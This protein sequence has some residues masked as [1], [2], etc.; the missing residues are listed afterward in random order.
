MKQLLVEVWI[1]NNNIRLYLLNYTKENTTELGIDTNNQW[2]H[3]RNT[4]LKWLSI[5]KSFY[6]KAF[7]QPIK[8]R[9]FKVLG[10]YQE[11]RHLRPFILVA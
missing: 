11:R 7:S 5:S 9:K 2:T 6:T 4:R 3:F 1:I 10:K 8:Q